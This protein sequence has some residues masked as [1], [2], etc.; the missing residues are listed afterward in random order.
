MA[1]PRFGRGT[2]QPR[3]VETELGGSAAAIVLAAGCGASKT[4]PA[5]SVRLGGG[6]SSTAPT[7]P[8]ARLKRRAQGRFVDRSRN[9]RETSEVGESRSG[10]PARARMSRLRSPRR[11]CRIDEGNR[12]RRADAHP[13][14]AHDQLGG[15]GH[16]PVD[17]RIACGGFPPGAIVGRNSFGTVGYRLCPPRGKQAL[18]VMGVYALESRLPLKPGF[19]QD[20][21]SEAVSSPD[22]GVGVDVGAWW[23]GALRAAHSRVALRGC[24]ADGPRAPVA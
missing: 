5:G 4:T 20:V 10:T 19:S 16:Q 9:V 11:A 2:F 6:S 18:V 21:L 22:V 3:D 24:G 15:G 13:W 14:Q 23:A 7:I 8:P 12:G 17:R 1:R